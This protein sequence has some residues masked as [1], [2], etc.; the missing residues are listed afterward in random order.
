MTHQEFIAQ[1][2]WKSIDNDGAYWK[3]CV[4]LTHAYS[5]NVLKS[6]HPKWNAFDLSKK[7]R[8]WFI[9]ILNTAKNFP[10]QGDIII[11]WPTKNNMYWHIAIVHLWW[12]MNVTV[13]EQNWW[14]GNWDW[15]WTNAIR[16]QNYDYTKSK[17]ICWYRYLPYNVLI[18][19]IML[20]NSTLYDMIKNHTIQ[21]QLHD[22]NMSLKAILE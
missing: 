14:T 6:D 17:V 11:F 2:L 19:D 20:K 3:Q 15:K 10:K 21:S 12:I 5:V 13:L 18:K 22:I 16:L 1:F 4:D 7:E 9:K 8:Y